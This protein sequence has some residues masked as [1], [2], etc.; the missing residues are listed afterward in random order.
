MAH[1]RS[2]SRPLTCQACVAPEQTLRKID[3]GRREKG[4]DRVRVGHDIIAA[5]LKRFADLECRV[6]VLVEILLVDNTCRVYKKMS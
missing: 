3:L 1:R 2:H 4:E 5:Q 6:R